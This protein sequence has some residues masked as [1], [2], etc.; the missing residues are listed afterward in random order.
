MVFLMFLPLH[1]SAI[2]VQRDTAC[3][4][5]EFGTKGGNCTGHDDTYFY[6]TKP[7]QTLAETRVGGLLVKY[8]FLTE[9]P[10]TRFFRHLTADA[11][12]FDTAGQKRHPSMQAFGG[13]FT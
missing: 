9:T 8:V 12:L 3:S 10:K 13:A 6:N 11:S 7:L 2:S 4:L 5:E 1:I